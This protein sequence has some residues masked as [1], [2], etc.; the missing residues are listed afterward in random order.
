MNF[1]PFAVLVQALRNTSLRL[2]GWPLIS[3]SIAAR[4]VTNTVSPA[5]RTLRSPQAALLYSPSRAQGRKPC[6]LG[7]GK[8]WGVS[9]QKLAV[10][11]RLERAEIAAAHRCIA[12][13]LDGEDFIVAAH[14]QWG[15]A[16]QARWLELEA[17]G[18]FS[19]TWS[20]YTW[21]S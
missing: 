15:K 7:V 16:R 12:L 10:E 14:R 6:P 21:S 4:P 8:P 1:Q 20:K 5:R 18:A 19:K 3:A 2:R 11:H 17:R 9:I 13:V